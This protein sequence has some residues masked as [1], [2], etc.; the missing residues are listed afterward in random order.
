MGT[1]AA[2]PGPAV[3]PPPSAG[4][5]WVRRVL[6]ACF[7]IA[8]VL[9]VAGFLVAFF[10]EPPSAAKLATVSLTP[11]AAGS[12]LSLWLAPPLTRWESAQPMPLRT[13]LANDSDAAISVEL[14]LKAASGCRPAMRAMD[15]AAQAGSEA[16]VSVP[17]HD[18]AEVAFSVDVSNCSGTERDSG[19]PLQI[20]YA[21]RETGAGKQAQAGNGKP[22]ARAEPPLSGP[23]ALEAVA[24]TSPIVFA[25]GGELRW[26]RWTRSFQA[27][28]T[29][30]KDLVWPLVLAVIGFIFQQILEG[31]SQERTRIKEIQEGEATKRARQQEKEQ[32]RRAERLQIL[33]HLLPEYMALVQKHYLLIARRIQTVETEWSAHRTEEEKKAAAT[34][35]TPPPVPAPPPEQ[36]TAVRVLTSILLMRRRLLHLFTKKGGIFFRTSTGEEIFGDFISEF[37]DKCHQ[38]FGKDAFESAA[39]IFEPQTTLP[40][41]I[42][43]LFSPASQPPAPG[44]PA[45]VPLPD[46]TGMLAKFRA[47]AI[48]PSAEE[49]YLNLLRLC[50]KVTRFE[51]DRIFYQ[52]DP[53]QRLEPGE[54]RNDTSGWYFDPPQLAISPEMCE[55]PAALEA[56]NEGK[57]EDGVYSKKRALRLLKA[58]CDQIPAECKPAGLT[59][60]NP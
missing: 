59:I 36:D 18:H 12:K 2:P 45:P 22:A 41:A 7:V 13:D 34:T 57:D 58:Y 10:R 33:T 23:V 6:S 35:P 9:P 44:A 48:D 20:G 3:P 25:T 16:R 56:A 37:I 19:I 5:R 30:V 60:P 17:P 15:P 28:Y 53:D 21:W 27:A 29:V 55:I 46:M 47:W 31:Q 24:S 43:T 14:S 32:T 26:M 42:R 49:G 11:H 1:L 39:L 51:C 52:T 54:S 50:E 40:L 8:A 38:V 4:S